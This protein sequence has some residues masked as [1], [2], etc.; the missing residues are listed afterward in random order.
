MPFT[1]AI[2]FLRNHVL[3]ET[4]TEFARRMGTVQSVVC[5]AEKRVPSRVLALA[6]WDKYEAA[7]TD[8]GF[9]LHDLLTGR[10]R[11]WALKRGASRPASRRAGLARGSV[12]TTPGRHE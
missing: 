2:D 1:T 11:R 10:P 6:I 3:G 5:D 8:A 9:S 7:L 4:Q 12:G